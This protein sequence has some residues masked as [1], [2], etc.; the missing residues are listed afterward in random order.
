MLY[1]RWE[2]QV[3]EADWR[4][5]GKEALFALITESLTAKSPPCAVDTF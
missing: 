3:E 5:F 4:P 2:K 1:D